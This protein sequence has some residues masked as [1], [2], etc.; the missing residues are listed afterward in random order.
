[1]AGE[2]TPT[3]TPGTEPTPVVFPT[4]PPP[5]GPAPGGMT[6]QEALSES[7]SSR[8]RAKAE[9][10]AATAELEKYRSAERARAQETESATQKAA[11]EKL[12]QEGRYHEAL[13]GV[14]DKAAAEITKT[15]TRVAE[16][17]VPLA[18]KSAASK[19]ANLA[20][21][22]IDDLPSLLRDHIALDPDTLEVYVKGADGKPLVDDR[23][24]P[25]PVEKF[26]TDWIGTKPYLLIDSMPR[27]HGQ[28]P[29]A[30]KKFS[31]EQAVADQA[32]YDA[33]KAE[34]PDGLAAAEKAYW[35]PQSA[36]ARIQA[37]HKSHG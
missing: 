34:D 14:E 27:R 25:V 24:Q 10:R 17:L 31:I 13:K 8:D 11:R 5:K 23:L 19:V 4:E 30:G 32:V 7:A 36:K 33:W 2:Q 15:R 28:S 1:M 29:G 6:W 37:A 9:V 35:S 26:I 3:P 20:R 12:E 18:I 21:E 22:S 16:R